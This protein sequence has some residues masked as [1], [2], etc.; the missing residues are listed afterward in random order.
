MSLTYD[1]ISS[2]R[3]HQRLIIVVNYVSMV[4][5]KGGVEKNPTGKLKLQNKLQNTLTEIS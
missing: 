3:H 4:T 1:S 2:L 5:T